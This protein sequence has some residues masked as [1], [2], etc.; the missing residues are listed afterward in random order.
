MDDELDE[1]FE[2]F[3]IMTVD[4]NMSDEAAYQQI[5][6]LYGRSKFLG[7]TRRMLKEHSRKNSDFYSGR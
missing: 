6:R 4:G 1:V 3:C 5:I 2:R 7:L